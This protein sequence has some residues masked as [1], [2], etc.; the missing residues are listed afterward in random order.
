MM[1]AF[2]RRFIILN[3][4][5]IGIVLLTA[6][7]VLGSF[8]CM[9]EYAELKNTMSNVL[10]PWNAGNASVSESGE[11]EEGEEQEQEKRISSKS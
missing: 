8:I 10:K 11:A 3:M 5:L 4:S 1:K 9:N 6:F 7:A 2:R